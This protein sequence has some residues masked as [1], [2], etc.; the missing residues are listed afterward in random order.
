MQYEGA[1]RGCYLGR[2]AQPI[3]GR[4][5]GRRGAPA[6]KVPAQHACSNGSPGTPESCDQGTVQL[7][8]DDSVTPL[9]H[10]WPL[11]RVARSVTEDPTATPD[12]DIVSVERAA[13][14]LMNIG[15]SP[16]TTKTCTGSVWLFV[17]V[18]D[19]C[20]C[21]DAAAPDDTSTCRGPHAATT[22]SARI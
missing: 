13:T 18:S 6:R 19:G 2:G 7:Y 8:D 17:T 3:P 10:D 1:G 9:V 22:T 14:S 21:V 15:L 4:T 12:T 16:C 20:D 5:T 11:G